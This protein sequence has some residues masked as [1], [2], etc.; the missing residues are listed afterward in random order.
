MIRSC[1][2]SD[3]QSDDI[4]GFS[5]ARNLNREDRTVTKRRRDDSHVDR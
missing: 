4:A 1:V 5:G 2:D 3:L